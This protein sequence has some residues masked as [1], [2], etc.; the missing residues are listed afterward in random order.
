MNEAV[1]ILTRI[2]DTRR[3]RIAN[4]GYSLSSRVPQERLHPVVPFPDENFVICEFKRKSPS[5]GTINGS[6]QPV[7]QAGLY[8]ELGA[9]AISVLTEED[10]F[11][12]SLTDLMVIKKTF[13]DT[14]VL[15]KDFL[16]D[17][18]DVEYSYRAGADCILLIAS[19]LS[20][21]TLADMHE[22]AVEL[23]MAT[24]IEVHDAQ[25][26]RRV[27]PLAPALVGV[28]ARDLKT[29]RIDPLGPL[30]VRHA[31]DWPCSVVYESGI[32]EEE[33]AALAAQ[34]GF[35]GILVGESVVRDHTRVPAIQRGL[36][37]GARSATAAGTR[38]AATGPAAAANATP[39]TGPAAAANATP[40]GNRA[41][42]NAPAPTGFW[43]DLTSRVRPRP[44]VKVCGIMRASDAEAAVSAGADLLGFVFAE[45]PRR[46]SVECVRECAGL[47][48]LKV[49]VVVARDGEHA[50]AVL[51]VEVQ[52][53]LAEGL[54]DA[55]QL[56][57]DETPDECASLAFP[58]YKALQLRTPADASRI[59]DFHCPRC[60][61]DAYSRDARGGTG[62]RLDPAILD[63][64]RAQGPL[65]VAGGIRPDN[66]GELVRSF[67]PELIDVSSGLEDETG[68]K[69]ETKIRALFSEIDAAVAQEAIQ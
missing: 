33:Q 1:D 17:V 60:L 66:V 36:A 57:G 8:R 24:L 59:P 29:F 61:V 53:L 45:S 19:L 58:Y 3:A 51:P 43:H 4:E 35:S 68:F 34:S 47:P 44:W 54:L 10:N 15:R 46:S 14:P 49:A 40:A 21:G 55:V 42:A 69:D 25:E 39:A 18:T 67:A 38:A 63:E 41:S 31:I 7:R 22:R 16:L 6:M 37:L 62:R 48:A 13:P 20:D 23:G 32:F 56:H 52:E 27:A 30:R 50:Q 9:D 64:V 2:A 11:G 12:G 65:W 5:R 28:N 26:A